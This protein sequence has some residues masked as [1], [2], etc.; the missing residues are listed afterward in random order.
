MMLNTLVSLEYSQILVLSAEAVYVG[1]RLKRAAQKG[2]RIQVS[3][4][5]KN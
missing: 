1:G 3:F 4:A 2:L 5:L